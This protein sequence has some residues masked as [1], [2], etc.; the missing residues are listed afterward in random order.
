MFKREFKINLKTLILW[1]SI[2]MTIFLLV[3][4]VYPSM[5]FASQE[6]VNNMLRNFP[7]E[8]LRTFNMDLI[9]I[10]T[11]F[12]W[13]KTEGYVFILL[14]GGVYSSLL[15]GSILLKEE[16]DE[17]I[18]YLLSKPVK[19]SKVVSAKV[20][21]GLVNISLFVLILGIFNYIGLSLS[22]EFNEKL[23]LYT[24]IAQLLLLYPLFGISFLIS[25]FFRKTKSV[26]GIVLSL[27][28]LSY[29]LQMIGALSEKF[30]FLKNISLFELASIRDIIKT[31]Q[32]SL[33]NIVIAVIIV[34]VSIA[35]SYYRYEKKEFL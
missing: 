32:I 33:R 29:A 28:F 4:L 19:R 25:S 13:Y 3:Y 34:I 31:N 30:R 7:E 22:G 1:T 2:L 35:L 9:S 20:L 5:N 15:G 8:I 6:A 24:V 11:A 17:T 14:L 27:V 18:E 21:C 16:N 12:G 10:D 23:Y 26:T